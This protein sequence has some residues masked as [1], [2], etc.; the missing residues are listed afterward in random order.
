MSPAS[1][2]D[3]IAV[4]ERLRS[5]INDHDLER[6]VGCFAPDYVN[7]TPAHPD[8]GFTGN[9]Q[10]RRN[11]SRILAGV[12]DLSAELVAV[13]SDGTTA[14]C[15]WAWRGTRTDGARHEMRGVAI[16]EVRGQQITS[17]RFYMEPVMRDGLDSDAA[18]RAAIPVGAGR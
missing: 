2:G 11:W 16:A 4:I 15:E 17:T 7:D 1:H 9:G 10:V 13:I 3:P 18:V 8:R 14:W 12:P 5:A 6:L